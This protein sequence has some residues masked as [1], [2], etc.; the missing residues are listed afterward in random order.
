MMKVRSIAIVTFMAT[1]LL[2]CSKK[3][4][5][6]E[7]EATTVQPAA[8]KV[9]GGAKVASVARAHLPEGCELVAAVDWAKFRELKSV[10]A[11]LEGELTKLDKPKAGLPPEDVKDLVEFLEKANIDLR[12][13]PTEIAACVNGIDK[14]SAGQDPR[15]VA[16]VGG[17]FRPGAAMDVLDS[18]TERLKGLVRRAAAQ[19]NAKSEPEIIDVAGHKTVHDK[20]E[21]LFLTQAKDGAFVLGNDRAQFE[22]ALTPGKAHESYK[23]TNDI[24]VVALTKAAAPLLGQALADS[25][26]APAAKSFVGAHLGVT[27]QRVALE[28]QIDDEKQVT[29]LKASLEGLFQQMAAAPGNPFGPALAGAK[30]TAEG[31]LLKLEVQVPAETL[32]GLVQQVGGSPVAPPGAM[33]AGAVPPGAVPSAGPAGLA[34]PPTK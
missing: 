21:N 27:E 33:P 10:K 7:A 29:A 8:A 9:D 16:I 19:G 20:T 14:A 1:S 25:P 4:K 24:V 3:E 34:K 31:K 5:A 32:N 13:D 26:F 12:T 22:K 18:V 6:P 28:A 2:A 15:F 23:L 17:K 30:V 11:N